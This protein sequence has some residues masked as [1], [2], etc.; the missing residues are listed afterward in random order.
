MATSSR[1]GQAA[2]GTA[3]W[4]QQARAYLRKADPVLAG[5]IA[6]RPD[7]DPRR[8]LTELPPMGLFG[9]L[10]FQIVGQQLSVAAT[11]RTLERRPDPNHHDLAMTSHLA[12]GE[13]GLDAKRTAVSGRALVAREMP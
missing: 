7:F 12:V 13:R 11:R 10:L 6:D 3:E 8:W 4:L 2:P 9:A 5:L 1:A